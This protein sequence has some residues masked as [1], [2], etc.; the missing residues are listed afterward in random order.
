LLGEWADRIARIGKVVTD[1]GLEQKV[2]ERKRHLDEQHAQEMAAVMMHAAVAAE[3]TMRQRGAF[4]QAFQEAVTAGVNLE[5]VTVGEF[6][7]WLRAAQAAAN[8][9]A[10]RAN[11][12]AA[13]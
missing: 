9:E 2:V 13:G 1:G 5:P 11:G 8:G 12:E 3:L 4:G 10:R 6:V 7:G